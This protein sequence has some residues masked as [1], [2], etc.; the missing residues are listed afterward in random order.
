MGRRVAAKGP[1]TFQATARVLTESMK[2][3]DMANTKASA[4]VS[5]GAANYAFDGTRYG[6]YLIFQINQVNINQDYN[7]Q[8]QDIPL[9]LNDQSYKMALSLSLA[10]K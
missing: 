6:P 5:V 3:S 8:V 10:H 2:P 9:F 1:V 4:I 7:A